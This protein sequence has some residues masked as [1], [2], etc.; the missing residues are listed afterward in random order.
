VQFSPD[1]QL[2]LVTQKT[3]NVLLTPENAIDAFAVGTDGYATPMPIRNASFGL[4]PF[5]LAFRADGTLVVVEAFNAA[6][7][8]SAASSYQVNPDGTIMVISGSVANGQTDTCWVVITPDGRFAFVSN[9]GSGTISSYSVG[10][11]GSLAL[12]QGSAAFLGAMSQPVDISL[13]ADGQFLYQLL[14]GPG[15]VAAFRIEADG[16]LAPLGVVAGGLPLAD[17]ISGLAS[18]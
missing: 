5:S 16:S 4:R 15:A 6:P 18:Y 7:N 1:G 11:D 2:I 12:L 14:R 13:S 10:P 8:M 9:F 3:T 17:G